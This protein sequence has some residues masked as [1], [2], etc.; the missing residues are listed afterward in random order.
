MRVICESDNYIVPNLNAR[1][2][3]TRW[4]IWS[5][6]SFPAKR[7]RPMLMLT[8]QNR[9]K[10]DFWEKLQQSKK[11]TSVCK[12]S[13]SRYCVRTS[14]GELWTF[15][16][17]RVHLYKRRNWNWCFDVMSKPSSKG[18]RNSSIA[19]H[20]HSRA[21]SRR[22]VGWWTTKP[23]I[24]TTTPVICWA[25][26]SSGGGDSSPVQSVG[27]EE[28]LEDDLHRNLGFLLRY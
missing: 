27:T 9:T 10:S 14:W 21:Q 2:P 19:I 15:P 23:Y 18:R 5:L 13:E 17:G 7:F 24:F 12:V 22:S 26:M 16:D 28:M 11:Q 6:C 8:T 4:Q 25:E 20:L 3:F 1:S